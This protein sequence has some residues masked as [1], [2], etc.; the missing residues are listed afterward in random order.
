VRARGSG[1]EFDQPAAG[2]VDFRD[3][4]LRRLRTI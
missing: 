2:V 1:I 3:G 4:R